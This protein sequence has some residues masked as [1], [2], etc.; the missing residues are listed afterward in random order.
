MSDTRPVISEV[1]GQIGHLILNRPAQLN[2]LTLEM[3]R[4]L[5]QQ[6]SAWADDPTV[7]VIVLRA[8][9]QKAFCAG[10]DIRALYDSFHAGEHG[11]FDFLEEEYVLDQFIHHYPKPVIGLLDGF[12]LGGGMGLAQG[13]S[14][15]LVTE[16]ARL[17]MPEVAIGYFPDVCASYFLPRLPGR[18]GEYLAVTGVHLA[19]ADALYA[20]LADHAVRHADLPALLEQ[21]HQYDWGADAHSELDSLLVAFIQQPEAA[22]TLP[23]WQTAID[24]HFAAADVPGIIVSLQSVTDQ[25]EAVWATELIELLHSRSPIAM[26]VS[27]ELIRRGRGHSLAYC[28]ELEMHLIRQWFTKGDFI[29]GVRALIVDKDKQPRWNPPQLEL[30]EAAKVAAFFTETPEAR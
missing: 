25:A 16:R 10:G 17:G 26:A 2:T 5:Q 22:A 19:P 1:H 18:L 8:T 11:H 30:L 29:E 15:R 3:I 7:R 13:C 14:H 21:L 23:Q 20:G 12:V 6:L 28:A 4:L 9:G 27:L 24:R